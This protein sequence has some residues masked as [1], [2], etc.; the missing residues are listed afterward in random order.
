V[1]NFEFNFSVYLTNA[2]VFSSGEALFNKI[3][4]GTTVRVVCQ[5]SNTLIFN[6]QTFLSYLICSIFS[7]AIT[8]T[9][10]GEYFNKLGKNI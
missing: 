8:S 7:K 4:F 1:T 2:L 6:Y 10:V 3:S 9:N 5:R